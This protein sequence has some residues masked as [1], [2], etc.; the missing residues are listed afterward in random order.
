V[1]N[2][3]ELR[4]GLKRSMARSHRLNGWCEFSPLLLS[5]RPAIAFLLGL[6]TGSPDH[7]SLLEPSAINVRKNLETSLVSSKLQPRQPDHLD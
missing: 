6:N 5:Q 1:L 2:F 7:L 3:C 4:I